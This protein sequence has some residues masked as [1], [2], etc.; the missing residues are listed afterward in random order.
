MATSTIKKEPI[1]TTER[2]TY[3]DSYSMRN[4]NITIPQGKSIYNIAVA[5]VLYNTYGAYAQTI[6]I[7]YPSG[8]IARNI[9]K[10]YTIPTDAYID[11]N[12]I[13]F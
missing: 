9:T 3:H 4:D 13:W 6:G 8:L 2:L 12:I 11:V 10:E 5:P 7:L 1:I